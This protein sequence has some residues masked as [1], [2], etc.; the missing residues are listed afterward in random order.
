MPSFRELAYK[1]SRGKS[2]TEEQQ[3]QFNQQKDRVENP[4]F[5][6]EKSV[7]RQLENIFDKLRFGNNPSK[8]KSLEPTP[9]MFNAGQQYQQKLERE[10]NM[11]HPSLEARP[12]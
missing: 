7:E 8:Q 4:Q 9:L 11:R 6:V 10:L 1:V 5:A 2:L 12:Y 3:K